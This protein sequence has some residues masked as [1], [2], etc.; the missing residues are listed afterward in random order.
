MRCSRAV[1]FFEAA[2][3]AC[4]VMIWRAGQIEA[5]IARYFVAVARNELL[6]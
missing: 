4:A 1:R 3:M 5:F 6:R 2:G